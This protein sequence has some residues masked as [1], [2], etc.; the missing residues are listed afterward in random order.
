[1]QSQM[2][3]MGLSNVETSLNFNNKLIDWNSVLADIETYIL[4]K[5]MSMANEEFIKFMFGD[6]PYI[7]Y[8]DTI[9]YKTIKRKNEQNF[10]TNITATF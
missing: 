8:E 4:N 7:E 6:F 2:G 3:L 10:N 5:R 1:M 9:N